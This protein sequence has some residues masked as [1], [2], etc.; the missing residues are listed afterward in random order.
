MTASAPTLDATGLADDEG[1][2]RRCIA[3]RRSLPKTALIRFVAAPDGSLTPDVAERLP[4]RGA[5]VAA[6]RAAVAHAAAKGLFARALKTPVRVSDGLPE[7]LA[8]QLLDRCVELIG[9]A[10]RGAGAVAGFDKVRGWLA[11]GR[12]GLL[13]HAADG[14]AQGQAKLAPLAGTIPVVGGLSA[15]ELGRAFG[16]DMVVHCAI[17][18]GPLAERLVI[19]AARLD[20][21]RRP[22]NDAGP[23]TTR[24]ADADNGRRRR[25]GSAQ[26]DL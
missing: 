15:A 4:G 14:S 13:L 7:R 26:G 12:A 6:D 10:R 16:R 5:Y 2:L 1:P 3:T 11:A 23:A 24:R 8:G 18:P 19:E 21:L 25:P 17:A 20:G 9:L 22:D